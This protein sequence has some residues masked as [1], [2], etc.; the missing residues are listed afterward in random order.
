M[1]LGIALDGEGRLGR[2]GAVSALARAADQLD[3]GSV[4]CLGPWAVTLAGAVAAVTTRVRIGVEQRPRDQAD[5]FGAIAPGRLIVGELLPWAP[6]AGF[7]AHGASGSSPLRLDVRSDQLDVAVRDLSAAK[8]L[9]VVEI[10]VRLVGDPSVDQALA[11][12]AELGELA[13]TSRGR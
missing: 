1:E 7:P 8:T 4:W 3:Y 6:R 11:A 12:Y 5:G 2:P 9:G 10:V 13:E